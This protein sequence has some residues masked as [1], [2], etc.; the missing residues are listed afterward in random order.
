MFLF[1]FLQFFLPHFSFLLL[2]SSF[3]H[4]SSL[5]TIHSQHRPC[6]HLPSSAPPPILTHTQ[7]SDLPSPQPCP[8]SPFTPA[9]LPPARLFPS[10]YHLSLTHSSSTAPLLLPTLILIPYLFPPPLP[11][12]SSSLLLIPSYRCIMFPQVGD[13][14]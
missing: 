3:T 13:K 1:I 11:H 9:I 2:F 10:L 4:S 7:A 14:R 5:I 12:F 6:F 8:L